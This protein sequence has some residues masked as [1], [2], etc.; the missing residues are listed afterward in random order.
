MKKTEEFMKFRLLII[1]LISTLLMTVGIVGA[2]GNQDLDATLTVT[3][4][5]CTGLDAA[6]ITLLG[7]EL[8]FELD[9]NDPNPWQTLDI[10]AILN[11]NCFDIY[12]D[13]EVTSTGWVDSSDESASGFESLIGCKYGSTGALNYWSYDF[14]GGSDS[15]SNTFDGYCYGTRSALGKTYPLNGMKFQVGITD[16]QSPPDA[17]EYTNEVSITLIDGFN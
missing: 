5:P 3:N 1:S 8:S 4:N 10:G 7:T 15:G 13:L 12:P 16:L 17:G 14:F 9:V 2:S 11:K 6:S